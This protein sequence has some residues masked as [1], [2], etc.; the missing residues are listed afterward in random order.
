M[1]EE[2]TA[3]K[4]VLRDLR[5]SLE[6]LLRE[7]HVTSKIFSLYPPGHNAL[8]NAIE[9]PYQ[10]FQKI[11]WMK[12]SIHLVVWG[13]DLIIE[14]FYLR[15]RDFVAD[16]LSDFDLLGVKSLVFSDTLT[17]QDLHCLLS[18]L[19]SR[20]RDTSAD[21]QALWMEKGITS[22]KVNSEEFSQVPE[23]E[24]GSSLLFDKASN[25]LQE[26][27]EK[28][29][30]FFASEGKLDEEATAEI[31]GSGVRWEV[32]AKS[33]AES[34]KSVPDEESARILKEVLPGLNLTDLPQSRRT[35]ILKKIIDTFTS[36]RDQANF[37]RPLLNDFLARGWDRRE[38]LELLKPKVV[39]QWSLLDKSERIIE[40]LRNEGEKPPSNEEFR[41]LV[42]GC[43]S[44]ENWQNLSKLLGQLSQILEKGTEQQKQRVSE[45]LTGMADAVSQNAPETFLG[46]LIQYSHN[47]YL[48]TPSKESEGLLLELARE[49]ILL[50]RLALAKKA[51]S[52]LGE[53]RESRGLGTFAS[54]R[55]ILT[56]TMDPAVVE[57][58]VSEIAGGK[59]EG[60]EQAVDL[61]LAIGNREAF[62]RLTEIFTNPDKSVRLS[63]LKALR[64]GGDK[65][66]WACELLLRDLEPL[67]GEQ[68][69]GYLEKEQWYRA[70]NAIFVIR[71]LR[72]PEGIN[73]LFRLSD[74]TDRRVRYEIV[75]AAEKIGGEAAAKLLMILA[76]DRD[77]K[78]RNRAI[79][80]LGQVAKAE[81]AQ[82]LIALSRKHPDSLP[83]LVNVLGRLGGEASRDFLFTI[84][85]DE[86][87]L[88][89]LGLPK[90]EMSDLRVLALSALAQIGD[91]A[92]LFK[93]RKYKNR[94]ATTG[95]LLKKRDNLQAAASSLL[96]QIER[97][98]PNTIS[99]VPTEQ[100][101]A[102]SD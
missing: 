46:S 16:L 26:E 38:I 39:K 52:V 4:A 23:G 56:E 85:E 90:K 60:R 64:R 37:L 53:H 49:L 92:S 70:R 73:I 99:E 32:A 58:L 21:L 45:Y 41:T 25:L 19:N 10:H 81:E 96:D 91:E 13:P 40:T 48:K 24:T 11:F 69:D 14:G 68:P 57:K 47:F 67:E 71:E 88:K 54:N 97:G 83:T 29:A 74:C 2:K 15:G 82:D 17:K 18:F 65:A 44:L 7:I 100:Q 31:F 101:S 30:R 59:P 43:V 63:C 51:L 5:K 9:S 3:D 34:V 77:P 78:V 80:A 35:A 84:L 102:L 89:E 33:I 50:D 93:L 66:L 42:K 75:T 62:R 87:Y 72:N 94:K 12:T 20:E 55:E 95:R 22:I 6:E 79:V 86:N 8:E 27:P 76:D 36:G 28:L 1:S 61:I 98:S